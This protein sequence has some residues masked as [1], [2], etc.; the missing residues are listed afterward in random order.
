MNEPTHYRPHVAVIDDEEDLCELIALR[1]EHHGFRVSSEQTCRGGLEILEREV[2]D[3][4]NEGRERPRALEQ[5]QG[6][7]G[8]QVEQDEVDDVPPGQGGEQIGQAHGL[9]DFDPAGPD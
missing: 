3:A 9:L 1:L 8:Q 6:R 2:V 5:A 7:V 4:V